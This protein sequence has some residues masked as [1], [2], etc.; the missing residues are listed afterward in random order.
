MRASGVVITPRRLGEHRTAFGFLRLLFASFVIVA[1]TPEYADGNQH[2]ELII[3]VFGTTTFGG[4]A[5]DGFFIISGFLITGSYL[6][7]NSVIGYLRKRVTRIYPGYAVAFTIS[8]LLFAP[9]GGAVISLAHELLYI[10][11]A[12]PMLRYPMVQGAFP[13]QPFPDVNGAMYTI[14]YEFRCYLL[15]IVLGTTGLLKRAWP[16]AV[17]AVALL[18]AAALLPD[19]ID[20]IFD[21]HP[22]REAILGR[23]L[24]AARM[25]GSFLFGATF[26]L[27]RRHIPLSGWWAV[28]AAASL[29]LALCW[30]VTANLGLAVFGSYLIFY[31]AAAGARTLLARVNNE[32]DISYGVYLYASPILNCGIRFAPAATP[33]WL[34]G[35]GTWI[36][37]CAYGWLSWTLVERPVMTWARGKTSRTNDRIAAGA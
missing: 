11:S 22:M 4:I 5:V 16:L 9:I 25:T 12:V 24:T 26:Y 35:G 7:S 10:A 1:H 30:P 20:H 32:T 23:P 33:L 19:A 28:G 34:I 31:A 13:G 29:C 17:L 37:A 3:R 18:L 27:A 2:R 21:N 15:V 14:A 36:L 6:K 8:V